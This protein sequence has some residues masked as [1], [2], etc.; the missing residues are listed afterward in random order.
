MF[1]DHRLTAAH[2]EYGRKDAGQRADDQA[3]AKAVMEALQ[4]R[5]AELKGWLE[6]AAGQ[7][8]DTG[9]M[10]SETKSALEAIAKSGTELQA[11][12]MEV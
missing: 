7:I 5:D 11:R 3:E 1:H 6:K 9:A 2:R 12:M 8:K 10:A 4:K